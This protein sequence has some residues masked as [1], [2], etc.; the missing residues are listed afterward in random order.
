MVGLCNEFRG[1]KDSGCIR[2]GTILWDYI[3]KEDGREATT[4]MYSS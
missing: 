4:A 1:F 2:E 3:G